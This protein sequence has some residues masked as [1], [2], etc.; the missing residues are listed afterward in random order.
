M[1][2]LEEL[3]KSGGEDTKRNS[4]YLPK[5]GGI[6]LLLLDSTLER[7]EESH[8]LDINHP[9]GSAQRKRGERTVAGVHVRRRVVRKYIFG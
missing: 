3:N 6:F 5:G 1:R 2:N 4:S 8:E 9:V 7:R